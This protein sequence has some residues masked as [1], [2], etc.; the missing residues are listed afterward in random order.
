MDI[1]IIVA[2]HKKYRMPDDKMYLP[3]QVGK[4]G[5]ESIGFTG[6]DTGDNISDKNANFCELTAIY[7][8]WKNLDADAVGLAHYRRHFTLKKKRNRFACVLSKDEAETLLQSCD[9]ILPQKQNYYIENLYSHYSHTHDSAH[10]ELLRSI[11]KEKCPEYLTEFEKLKKRTSAH[12][13]NMFVMKKDAF[14]AYCSW[15]FPILFE[16]EKMINLDGYNAFEARLFGR[17]SELMMDM[18]INTNSISYTEIPFVYME[19]I[20]WTR[21]IK[22]FICAKFFGKKYGKSF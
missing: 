14:D 20:N 22:S 2:A 7:W 8:A 3:L 4:A 13:F 21:K 17:I 18:W 10:L 1:R 11:L 19:K 12:M 9:V 5:K 16:M 15:M 6:D